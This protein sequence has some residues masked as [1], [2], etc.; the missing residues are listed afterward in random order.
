[1]SSTIGSAAAKAVPS[2]N[3][4]G[5]GGGGINMVR[6]M[7]P[8]YVNRVSYRYIDTSDNNIL[9]GE[10]F[11]SITKGGSGL[12]REKNDNPTTRAIAGYSDEV[13]GLADINVIVFSLSGGSGSVSGPLLISE[14]AVRRK[15]LVIA[16]VIA[17]VQSEK[18]TSNTLATLRTLHNI[19]AE[20]DI[21]LPIM[22]FNNAVAG[23]RFVNDVMPNKMR[24]LIDILTTPTFEID[25]QDRMHFVDVQSVNSDAGHGMRVLYVTANTAGPADD[26]KAEVWIDADDHVY[27][28]LL[29]ISTNDASARIERL[30]RAKVSFEGQ[31]L[32]IKLVSMYAVIGN[33][34]GVFEKLNDLIQHRLNDFKINSR[35]DVDPFAPNGTAR[36]S[37]IIT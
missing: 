35:Q 36:A 33:P 16:I 26:T 23:D 17:S 3:F 4:I 10:D 7:L 19:T 15:K 28:S 8:G 18:H 29:A 24:H 20:D 9:P 34:S 11:I 27:D 31:F 21:Y 30:P 37:R 32:D 6:R 5:C 1:M 22:I 14:I 13:L 12:K 25:R 2:I